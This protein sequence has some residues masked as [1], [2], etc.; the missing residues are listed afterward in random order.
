MAVVAT[1]LGIVLSVPPAL[2]AANTLAPRWVVTATRSLLSG[3]R[4]VP[5]LVW[6]L[7]CVAALGFGPLAGIVALTLYSVG[8]LTKFFSESIESVDDAA[9]GALREI[10]AGPL[11]RFVHAIVPA[12]APLL[13][14]NAMFMLE[15]NVRSASVL[16]IV[17]A[18]GIGWHLKQFLD[19]RDFPGA[20]ACLL[21]V[22][23]V[24]LVLDAASG[25]V[26]RWAVTR[27]GRH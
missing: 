2:L 21:L 18:G 7:F 6:A 10:G 4:V 20:I 5:S 12:A 11:Q 25:R 8:Y 13:A 23:G 3:V 16:G 17:D 15:Y 19:Y 27:T 24:V 26:R 22:L 9:P 14:S 1:T